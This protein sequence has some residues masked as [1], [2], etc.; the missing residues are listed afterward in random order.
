MELRELIIENAVALFQTHGL[1]FTMQD[2]ARR[3]H[4]AKKTIY[5]CFESKQDLLCAMLDDGFASIQA[6]KRAVLE[7]DLPL[8]EKL[9]KTMIAMPVQ[10]Q[11]LDFRMLNE[12]D[13]KYPAV[14]ARLVEHLEDNW[15]PVTALIEQGIEEGLIRP[16]PVAIVRQIF[17]ASIESF[18]SSDTLRK[19]N[20]S[21]SEAMEQL[22]DII[23]LGIREDI[24][25]H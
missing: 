14:Y 25:D 3:L 18:L 21:Y 23:M 24:H 2:V 11:I 17:T 1:R 10:Y 9:R 6:D 22:M 4:I 8:I 16:V 15:E 12:L 20:I 19:E 7:S 5:A 13:E